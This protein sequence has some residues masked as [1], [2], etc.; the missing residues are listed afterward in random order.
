MEKLATY[1]VALFIKQELQPQIAKMEFQ[2]IILTY[3][4]KSYEIKFQLINNYFN[5]FNTIFYF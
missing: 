4:N 3:A 5:I 1:E 2:K